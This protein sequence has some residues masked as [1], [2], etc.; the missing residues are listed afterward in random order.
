[1]DHRGRFRQDGTLAATNAAAFTLIELLV[2]IAIISLL[3]AVLLPAARLAR[4][5]GRRSV[6]L[7]NL[8]QLTLAWTAYADEHDDKLVCGIAFYHER[9]HNSRVDGWLG[10]AFADTGSRSDVMKRPDKGPLWS[11]VGGQIDAY[12]CPAGWRD[13]PATYA[14]VAAANGSLRAAGTYLPNGAGVRVGNTVLRL[15]RLTDII[16]PGAADRAVFVDRA[17][18]P[19]GDFSIPYLSARWDGTTP[20]PKHHGDG[21]T[22]SMA[23][24]HAEYWKWKGRET[25]AGLPR[26]ILCDDTGP[27]MESLSGGRDYEPQTEDGLYDQQRLRRATWGRLG[28]QTERSR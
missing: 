10:D 14:I 21:A 25:C 13:H 19:R 3:V 9:T 16:S 2:V 23:D 20:P 15:S 17:H 7:S 26:E 27:V 12:R 6:C 18:V 5:S 1:M 28:H 8:R 4:E 24:G 22:L 11:Y